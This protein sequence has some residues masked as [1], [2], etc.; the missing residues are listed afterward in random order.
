MPVALPIRHSALLVSTLL[1]VTACE[2]APTKQ[3]RL[4]TDDELAMLESRV[5]AEVNK[6]RHDCI[7]PEA[8]ALWKPSGELAACIDECDIL[9]YGADHKKPI[10]RDELFRIVTPEAAALDAKCGALVSAAFERAA[11]N[12]GCSPFQIGINNAEGVDAFLP[13]FHLLHLV[14]RHARAQ[15][16]R[17]SAARSLVTALQAFQDYARGRTNSF[18]RLTASAARSSLALGLIELLADAHLTHSDL[19]ALATSLDH[20]I[21]SEPPPHEMLQTEAAHAAF[22]YGLVPLEGA[23]WPVPGGRSELMLSSLR[24]S[25]SHDPRDAAGATML[26]ALESGERLRTACPPSSSLRECFDHL[27]AVPATTAIADGIDL[28]DRPRKD[29][30]ATRARVKREIVDTYLASNGYA[31]SIVRRAQDFVPLVAL[32]LRIE[33]LRNGRCP[34]ATELTV[35]PYSALRAPSV[36]GDAIPATLVDHALLVDLPAWVRDQIEQARKSRKP[37]FPP[38]PPS[39]GLISLP[40]PEQ[41]ATH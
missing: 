33:I 37:P 14:A 20:L 11:A 19:D 40:C 9:D 4:F 36:L 8:L 16:D 28:L 10:R 2:K 31:S 38:S 34:T 15:A 22:A 12:P 32:R 41:G 23:G 27:N 25:T 6:S 29:D 17:A 1:L 21:A 24:P 30:P 5:L 3:S 35:P 18:T 13:R 26:S 39:P 7:R